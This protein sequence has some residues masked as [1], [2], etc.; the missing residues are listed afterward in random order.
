MEDDFEL[1]MESSLNQPMA[2]L[3]N[4]YGHVSEIHGLMGFGVMGQVG[5]VFLNTFERILASDM[6]IRL[7]RA[8]RGHDGS[9]MSVRDMYILLSSSDIVS[10][11]GDSGSDFFSQCKRKLAL[12]FSNKKGENLKKD[13]FP[14]IKNNKKNRVATTI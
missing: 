4:I 10:D 5:S 7:D 12:F 11:E 9:F 13:I 2:T 1:F 6:Y 8:V 14:S 3:E